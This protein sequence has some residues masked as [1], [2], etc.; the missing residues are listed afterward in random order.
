MFEVYLIVQ[1]PL[2]EALNIHGSL[3][4]HEGGLGCDGHL[5]G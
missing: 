5:L 1:K 4:I 3:M 2:I